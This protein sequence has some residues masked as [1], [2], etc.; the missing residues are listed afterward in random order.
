MNNYLISNKLNFKEEGVAK[1][2]MITS[3]CEHIHNVMLKNGYT[4]ASENDKQIDYIFS[5]GGDGTMMHTMNNFLNKNSVIIGINAGNVGFLTPYNI[6]DVFNGDVF[7]FLNKKDLRIEGRSL[8]QY[9]Y[10]GKIVKAVNE[11][12]FAGSDSNF[13]IDYSIETKANNHNSRAGHYRANNLLIS[14]PCGSTAY[15]MNAGGA[16]LDPS[17]KAM[18]VLMVAPTAIGIRPMVFHDKVKLIIRFKSNAR[19]FTDGFE[20]DS[21]KV[22]DSITVSLLEEEAKILLPDN[23]NFYS[24]LSEKL[25]WNNGQKV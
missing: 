3:V 17:I 8:L 7:E 10:N 20:S 13:V 18:Q 19:I 16:I 24:A 2:N 15:N 9:E 5:V 6:D 25:H 4:Q 23:W 14:G 21:V 1:Q 11:Y 12:A 22:G